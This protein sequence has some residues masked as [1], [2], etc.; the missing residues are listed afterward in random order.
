M[1]VSS[2][3]VMV[4]AETV[5]VGMAGARDA[6]MV[7]YG[8]HHDTS[9]ADRVKSSRWRVLGPNTCARPT[10]GVGIARDPQTLS[11]GAPTGCV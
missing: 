2:A 3:M 9:K 5:A 4:V 8:Q 6:E 10:A 11:V 7:Q 1:E